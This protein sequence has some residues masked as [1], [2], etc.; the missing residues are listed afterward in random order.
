VTKTVVLFNTFVEILSFIQDFWSLKEQH[1]F[2]IEIF[3]N[4]INDFTVSFD[5]MNASS[6]NL[7]PRDWKVE[8]MERRR[9]GILK[10]W[11]NC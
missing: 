1:L 2:E 5:Q 11:R 9:A 7:L 10:A 6:I 3:C 4:I 8:M